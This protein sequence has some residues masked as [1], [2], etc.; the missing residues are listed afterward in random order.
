V[1]ATHH[2]VVPRAQTQA[3]DSHALV[4]ESGVVA[5]RKRYDRI[6]SGTILGDR[7]LL[8]LCEPQ[9]IVGLS[10]HGIEGSAVAHRY[11]AHARV[12][13]G[14][15]VE[16]LIA[17]RPD[18]LLVNDLTDQRRMARLREAGVVV[19]D[20]GPMRGLERLLKNIVTVAELIG[21]PERGRLLADGTLGRM[22]ATAADIP[23]SARK[24]AIYVGVHGNQLYGG[25]K[26][27]SY[28]DVLI[29]AGLVDVAAASYVDWPAY[30]AEVLLA[31]NPEVILTPRGDKR[32]L[33]E[34]PNLR[35]L[36]ACGPQGQ[37][38][39]LDERLLVDPSLAMLDASLALRNAVYGPVAALR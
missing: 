19:F 32:F 9:R 4:D 17:L 16:A 21:V 7:L 35:A 34:Q 14:G 28:H 27:T 24:T 20:L 31:L 39:E 29:H 10:Q 22:R 26:N 37:V 30:T 25:T 13:L 1:T 11:G 38:V 33:C 6:A 8:E 12:E 15:D 2:A 5:P 18:L 3:T 36:R 23:V